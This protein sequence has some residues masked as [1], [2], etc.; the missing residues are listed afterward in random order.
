MGTLAEIRQRLSS[1]ERPADLIKAGFAR[2]SVYFEVKKLREA[3]QS[4]SRGARPV[5]DELAELRRVKERVKLQT[6]IADLEENKA[7][8][9]A[10]LAAL[11]KEVLGLREDI[12]EAAGQVLAVVWVSAGADGQAAVDKANVWVKKALDKT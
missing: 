11:E 3:G 10:R 9:P 6:E 4:G 8:L 1:G 2:S 5:E 12:Y 7:R